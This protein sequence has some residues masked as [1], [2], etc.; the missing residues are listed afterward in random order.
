[1]DVQGFLAENTRLTLE[2]QELRDVLG[3]NTTNVIPLRPAPHR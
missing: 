2:N 3:G 1:M